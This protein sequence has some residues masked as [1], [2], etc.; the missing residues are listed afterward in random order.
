MKVFEGPSLREMNSL[1]VDASASLLITIETEED[2]ITLPTFDP[3]RDCMLGGGSNTVFATDVPGTVY[4]NRILGKDII[5]HHSEHAVVEVGAG[6]NWH[7]LVVWSLD[8]GLSGLENLS[9]I[10]GQAGAAPIQNIGA[11]GVELSSVLQRVTAWDWQRSLWVDFEP[12]ECT[13]GYRDSMFKSTTP[14][15]YLITSIQL[16]L[17]RTFQPQ[18]DYSGLCEELSDMGVEK[19]SARAV[20]DAVVRL[21]RRKLPDPAETGNAGSF[22]KNPV[23]APELADALESAHPGLP[24]WRLADGRAKLSAAWMI[25]HCGLKGFRQ[26]NAAVSGQHALVLLNLGSASGK[27]IVALAERVQSIVADRFG[28]MLEPEPRL[29]RF[30]I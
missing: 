9:L 24:L 25:E 23:V 15:R 28:I 6:E 21:R 30:D 14:D 17:S 22:F 16:K 19:I 29:I 11:Y 7:Q 18:L 10:P 27:E 1:G 26:G 4:H 5:D 8:Q 3:A 12:S 20:S 13:L 2:V